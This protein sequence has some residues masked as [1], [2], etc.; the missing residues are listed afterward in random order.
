M[1]PEP[2]RSLAGVGEK[3]SDSPRMP[4]AFPSLE[5]T[6]VIRLKYN[7]RADKKQASEIYCPEGATSAAQ[8]RRRRL[9]P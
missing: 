3:K 1:E 9:V 2:F 6:P 7:T 5:M 8:R 4:V